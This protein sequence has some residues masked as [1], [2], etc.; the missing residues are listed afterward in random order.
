MPASQ[1]GC[2]SV[3]P[4]SP[5]DPEHPKGLG[6][7]WAVSAGLQLWGSCRGRSRGPLS[8]PPTQVSNKQG[9][10]TVCGAA[11]IL[12]NILEPRFQRIIKLLF[13][14]KQNI[15]ASP[16]RALGRVRREENEGR[17]A[18][19]GWAAFPRGCP[20]AQ[21]QLGAALLGPVT[22][23]PSL[24]RLKV[25]SLCP[26]VPPAPSP[27]RLPGS[28]C[29]SAPRGQHVW[30]QPASSP[31]PA[32][33]APGAQAELPLKQGPAITVGSGCQ[34]GSGSG[35]VCREERVVLT[36]GLLEPAE[37]RP[38]AQSPCSDRPQRLPGAA[39]LQQSWQ[40]VACPLLLAP[41]ESPSLCP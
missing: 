35:G 2:N 39:G 29:G 36:Q 11:R 38:G 28:S 5:R 7:S 14:Y 8:L 12:F 6:V 18:G 4:L 32:A 23:S 26:D 21:N 27:V 33:A 16:L 19:R 3:P 22:R 40:R 15:R 24:W 30:P 1:T 34:P 37:S 25:L 13:N 9:G 31:R 20:A 41:W 17:F 10:K